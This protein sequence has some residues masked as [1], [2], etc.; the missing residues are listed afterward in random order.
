MR[1]TETQLRKLIR[2]QLI[3]EMAGM[4]PKKPEP[5]LTGM[6]YIKSAGM[7]AGVAGLTFAL[8]KVLM[9]IQTNG[10]G[11]EIALKLQKIADMAQEVIK[12]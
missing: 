5:D 3:K 1:M 2:K 9:D 12:E 10:V 8:N 6:D 11:H 4:E 7:G